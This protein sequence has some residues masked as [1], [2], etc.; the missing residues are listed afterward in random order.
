M[1]RFPLTVRYECCAGAAA[2]ST[3]MSEGMASSATTTPAAANPAI[4]Q[5]PRAYPAVEAAAGA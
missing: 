2:G 3:E 5:K 1:I 4:T